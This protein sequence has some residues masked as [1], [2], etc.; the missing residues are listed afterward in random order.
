[1]FCKKS[2]VRQPAMTARIHVPGLHA[3]R[4][5]LHAFA[6]YARPGRLFQSAFVSSYLLRLGKPG[7]GLPVSLCAGY[8]NRADCIF[9]LPPPRM[10]PSCPVAN[11]CLP[12]KEA[13]SQKCIDFRLQKIGS[14]AFLNQF[15]KPN[16]VQE[17]FLRHFSEQKAIQVRSVHHF[18]EQKMMKDRFAGSLW[19]ANSF[20]IASSPVFEA[21]NR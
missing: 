21:E 6:C 1:M 3:G 7:S 9:D 14:K 5:F 8:A 10:V 17:G 15:C 19:N 13:A 20:K 12:N 18:S 4:R 2:S 11:E 16:P